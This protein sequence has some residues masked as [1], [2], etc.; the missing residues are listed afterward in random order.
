[1]AIETT[2]YN[3]DIENNFVRTSFVGLLDPLEFYSFMR[4]KEQISKEFDTIFLPYFR[5]AH[6][7]YERYGPTIIR[8]ESYPN[9]KQFWKN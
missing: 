9:V 1:M 7:E 5:A 2:E 3:M 6:N 8:E 4:A